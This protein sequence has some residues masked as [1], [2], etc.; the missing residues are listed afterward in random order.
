MTSSYDDINQGPLLLDGLVGAK[1]TSLVKGKNFL[2]SSF[3]VDV[4]VHISHQKSF[5]GYVHSVHIYS[6]QSL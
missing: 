6:A 3:G 4:K 2:K 5:V 1:M